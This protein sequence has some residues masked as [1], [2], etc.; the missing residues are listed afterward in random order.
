M[1][2]LASFYAVGAALG[3]ATTMWVDYD[4]GSLFIVFLLVYLLLLV[5]DWLARRR[6]GAGSD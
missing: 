3:A 6:Q 2:R 5:A 4:A 1:W